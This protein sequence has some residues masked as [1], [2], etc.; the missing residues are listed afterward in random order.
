MWRAALKTAQAEVEAR[1]DAFGSLNLG[2]A[3]LHLGDARGAARAFDAAQQ[4]RPDASLDPTRPASAVGGWPWRTLWYRFEPLD[5][6]LR[7]GRKAEVQRLTAATLHN[8][9]RHKE[10]LAWQRRSQ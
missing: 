8:T 9:P 10:L 4:L 2:A 5:A 6:Y 1:P 3:K 7:V